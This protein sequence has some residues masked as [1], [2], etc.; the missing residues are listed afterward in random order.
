MEEMFV[1]CGGR[2]TYTDEINERCRSKAGS[3]GYYPGHEGSS[4]KYVDHF[5]KNLIHANVLN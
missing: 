1:A 5:L 2:I 4:P 3:Y